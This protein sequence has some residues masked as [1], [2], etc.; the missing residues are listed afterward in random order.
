MALHA[1][2]QLLNLPRVW[3]GSSYLT[4]NWLYLDWF[5]IFYHREVT[6]WV[7]HHQLGWLYIEG[8]NPDNSGSTYL[9]LILGHSRVPFFLCS[10]TFGTELGFHYL[11]RGPIYCYSIL[12]CKYSSLDCFRNTID[13]TFLKLAKIS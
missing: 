8:S 12:R 6:N 3:G 7:H 5:G 10:V 2:E 13:T 4:E 9:F 1:S 11:E